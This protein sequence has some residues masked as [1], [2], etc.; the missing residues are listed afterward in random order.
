MRLG[1]FTS[2]LSGMFGIFLLACVVICGLLCLVFA[3]RCMR[4]TAKICGAIAGAF[5]AP[6]VIFGIFLL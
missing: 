1:I 4:R 6:L 3:C 5:L 2:F